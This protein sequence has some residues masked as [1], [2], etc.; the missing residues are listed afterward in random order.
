MS[1]FIVRR[2]SWAGDTAEAEDVTHSP[3][4]ED[5]STGHQGGTWARARRKQILSDGWAGAGVGVGWEHLN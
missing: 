4:R 1:K 3:Q 5:R 2:G